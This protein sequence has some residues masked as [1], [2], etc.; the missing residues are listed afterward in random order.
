MQLITFLYQNSEIFFII[1]HTETF[2]LSLFSSLI[3][4]LNPPNS[5]QAN[6]FSNNKGF[7]N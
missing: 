2:V 3:L 1:S 4:T 7:L 6:S 5:P